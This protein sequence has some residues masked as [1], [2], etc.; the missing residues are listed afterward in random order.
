MHDGTKHTRAKGPL[1][2]PRSLVGFSVRG[3]GKAIATDL[4]ALQGQDDVI[5]AGL[6]FKD[7]APEGWVP[8][9]EKAN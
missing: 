7:R 5:P 2:V 3:C 8:D 9:K 1:Q 4:T 6:D